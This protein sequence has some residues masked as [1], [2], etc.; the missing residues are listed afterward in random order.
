[1]TVDT[2]LVADW[3]AGRSLARGLPPPVPDR[4]GLRVDVG[5]ESEISRW[6]FAAPTPAITALT[7]E[8]RHPAYPVRLAGTRDELKPL[9]AQGWSV[10]TQNCLM[11]LEEPA[12]AADKLPPGYR[13]VERRGD[14]IIHARIIAADGLLAASGYAAASGG[15]FVYDR[16]LTVPAHRRR[17]LGS[18][19][20]T[21]LGRAK[22]SG[23]VDVLAATAAGRALYESL[24]WRAI[25]GWTAASLAGQG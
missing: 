22:A 17:G 25:S 14:A 11:V 19:L 21:R 6:V 13:W 5:N 24:G 12:A 8:I 16:I 15:A 1:M 7:M 20:M 10:E 4:G 2:K 3:L 9:L 23:T 18:A